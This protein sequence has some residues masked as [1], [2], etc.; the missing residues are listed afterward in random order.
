MQ[1]VHGGLIFQQLHHL[2]SSPRFNYQWE[3]N[4]TRKTSEFKPQWDWLTKYNSFQPSAAILNSF[5][6]DYFSCGSNRL[7][8]F[9]L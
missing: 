7:L 1:K 4:D 8:P 3:D 6:P 5:F 9:V 2:N